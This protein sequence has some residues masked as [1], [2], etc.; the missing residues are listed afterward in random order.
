MT[1][2][3]PV[4]E[5]SLWTLDDIPW[6]DFRPDRVDP[7][8]LKIVK[9][10]AL[11]EFNGDDYAEY[12]CNVFAGDAA[13]QTAARHW[14]VEEVQHGEALGRWAQLADP[15]W[16]FA[17]AVKAFRAGYRVDISADQSVRG[18]RTGELIARCIV[19][20]GTSSYYSALA[21]RTEE[22]VLKVIC[23][24][25]ATD[26][27]RHYQLFYKHM[28][29][30]VAAEQLR[31]MERLRIALGRIAESEDDELAFAF[32]AANAPRDSDYDRKSALAAY[33]GRASRLYRRRHVTNLVPMVLRAAGL[34]ARG[35]F[36]KPLQGAVWWLWSVNAWRYR[37][38]T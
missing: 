13:F 35:W 1:A 30:Y 27:F 23:R 10:A 4:P 3:K 8:V 20:T 25:I 14:A 11:V 28:K 7:D 5:P 22:P 19:E 2:A 24:R 36:L 37:R 29:R 12:L 16:D 6:A 18:T 33:M 34:K 26:E 31:P 38:M 32:H 17:A 9:A 15:D 21:D